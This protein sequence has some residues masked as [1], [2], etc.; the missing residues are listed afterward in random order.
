MTTISKNVYIDKLGAIVKKQNNSYHKI[1]EMKHVDVK[2]K[3]YM[4]I[5]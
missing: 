4:Y 1:I 2:S 5:Y 3:I